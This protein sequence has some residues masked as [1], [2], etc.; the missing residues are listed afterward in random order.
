MLEFL[1]IVMCLEQVLLIL[2]YPLSKTKTLKD[3][4]H[5]N[6]QYN[7]ITQPESHL[8]VGIVGK[9]YKRFSNKN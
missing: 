9:N 8:D 5:K 2:A 3:V 7:T 4:Y 1:L 6:K